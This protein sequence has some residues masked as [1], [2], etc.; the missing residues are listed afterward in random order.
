MLIVN[1]VDGR[2]MYASHLE[3]DGLIACEAIDPRRAL[4]AMRQVYPDVV[5]TDYLF[6]GATIDGPVFIEQV[7]HHRGCTQAA[8]VVVSGYTH[9]PM[10]RAARPAQTSVS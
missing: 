1:G 7:R 8:I 2:Q 4:R 5:V 10:T 3:H 9:G 6:P